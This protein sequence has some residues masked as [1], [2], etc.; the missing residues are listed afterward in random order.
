MRSSLWTVLIATG[1]GALAAGFLTWQARREV[2]ALEVRLAALEAR[3]APL[4]DMEKRV[5]R[6][7]SI[8]MSLEA[9]RTLAQGVR[10][11][12]AAIARLLSALA[13]PDPRVDRLSATP[14]GGTITGAAP[15]PVAGS[16]VAE[17]LQAQEI[18][19]SFDFERFANGRYS[20]SFT[21]PESQLEEVRR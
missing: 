11:R 15:T 14:A 2:V 1:T 16:E 9:R 19:R 13:T 20:L 21:L 7:Q 17:R 12:Q 5:L 4:A 10:G 8:K 18:I 3:R 6:Y